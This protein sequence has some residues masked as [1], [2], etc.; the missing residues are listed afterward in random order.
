[1]PSSICHSGVSFFSLA[2]LRVFLLSLTSPWPLGAKT[3]YTLGFSETLRTKNQRTYI[4]LRKVTERR[5]MV[6]MM[7]QLCFGFQEFL[8][9][10]YRRQMLNLKRCT[11]NFFLYIPQNLGCARTP[12]SF[13]VHIVPR[14]EPRHIY[15]DFPCKGHLGFK[16]F[17]AWKLS[18]PI[19]LLVLSSDEE[20]WNTQEAR[21]ACV[22]RK[23]GRHRMLPPKR[24]SRQA[25]QNYSV[26]VFTSRTK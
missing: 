8:F 16:G 4:D 14:K 12:G 20:T 22:Q 19:L 10:S 5:H 13:P 18:V 15:Q 9:A 23:P 7:W 1:M 17:D 11:L 24:Q 3:L 26:C 21:L 6:Y 2:S 25:V